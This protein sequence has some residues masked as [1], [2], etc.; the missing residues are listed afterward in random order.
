MA[1]FLLRHLRMLMLV[2]GWLLVSGD[3]ADAAKFNRVLDIGQKAPAWKDLAGTDDKS[4]SLADLKQAKAVV[5][6][7]MCNHCPVAKA[8]EK[9]LIQQA[10]KFRKSGV[11]TVAISVSLFEADNFAAMQKRAREKKYPFPYLQDES[12][13][14]GR[15]YGALCTPHVFLLDQKRRVAYMGSIDDS[16]YPEKVEEHY[17]QDAIEAVLRHQ[18]VEIEETKPVGCPIDYR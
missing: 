11:A 8:Y 15:A 12:Q 7:F 3:C 13:K 16:M 4:H 6:V 9:R 2:A 10:R 5:V 14:I 18:A 1:T 17:L